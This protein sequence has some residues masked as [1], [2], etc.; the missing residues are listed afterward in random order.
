MKTLN[1]II[2]QIDSSERELP[3]AAVHNVVL[4]PARGSKKERNSEG[5]VLDEYIL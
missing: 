3:G 5:D 1:M 2:N 4:I